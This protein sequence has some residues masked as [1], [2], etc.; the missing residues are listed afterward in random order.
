LVFFYNYS[1]WA[2]APGI[3]LEELYVVP[4]YRQHG[5]GQMLIQAMACAAEAAG[6]IKMDWV[7]LKDNE[8]ALCFYDKVEAKRIDKWHVLKVDSEGIRRLAINETWDWA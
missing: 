1:T 4:D 6:C 5:Y 8:K 3:C 7:C 2:A